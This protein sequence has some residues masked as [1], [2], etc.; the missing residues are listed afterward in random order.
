MS[1]LVH[2]QF[3]ETD[4]PDPPNRPSVGPAFGEPIDAEH[5]AFPTVSAIARASHQ[6]L[7]DCK[8]GFRAKNLL[9]AARMIDSGQ[10]DLHA[11]RS[12]EYDRAWKN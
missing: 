8:L 6:Q 3:V 10:L 7:W 11:L 1:H 2:R 4:R 9:A 12:M 5:H